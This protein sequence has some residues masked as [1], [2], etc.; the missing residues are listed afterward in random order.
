MGIPYAIINVDWIPKKTQIFSISQKL[1]VYRY[2]LKS[3]YWENLNPTQPMGT[4]K[5]I[6]T[7]V[8]FSDNFVKPNKNIGH[9]SVF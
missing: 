1:I 2:N 8:R 3:S 7:W 4:L 5:T 9:H 6:P